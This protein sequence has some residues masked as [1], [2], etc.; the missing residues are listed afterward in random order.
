MKVKDFAKKETGLLIKTD[1]GK[2]KLKAVKENIINIVYTKKSEFRTKDSYML[3]KGIGEN[4]DWDIKNRED[5]LEFYTSKIKIVINKD[6]CSFKYYDENKNMLVKEPD[7]GGKTLIPIDVNKVIFAES[8]ELKQD[9]SAD[10]IKIRQEKSKEVFDRQAYSF[11]L[12]FDWDSEEA[13]YG[14]GSHEEGIMNYRGHQQLL[15]Q[16]NLKAVLPFI[17]STKGYGVLLDSYSLMTFHDDMYGSYLWSEVNEELNY[18]FIS[19]PEFDQIISGY[20]YL[21]GKAP[22]FPRWSLGYIQSK[23]RYKD[24]QE[25]IEVVAEHRKRGIPLDMIVLDWQSWPANL[26]G[27]KSLDSERFPDPKKMMEQIH[28]KNARLMVSIWPKMSNDGP[29]QREMKSKGFLLGDRSTYDAFDEKARELYWQQVHRGLFSKDIDAWWCDCTEPFDA[30]WNGEYKLEPEQRLTANTEETKKYIDPEYLNAYSLLHAKGIYRGQRE[31]TS[32]KRVVNLTRSS[33]AGQQRYGAITWSGDVTADWETFKKQIP[34]GLNFCA[35][36]VPYWTTDIG[37]FFV[38][39]KEQWFWSGNFEKGPKDDGYKELYVRW[40][41]FGAFTPFFRSH[42]TDFPR[43]I[44][45]FGEPGS[46]FYDTLL[47]FDKLRYRLIPYIYSLAAMVSFEDYTMM[48]ALAFDFRHDK[49]TYDIDDQ[50][51]FGP[52]LLVNPV[53]EAL[54]YRADSR[55]IKGKEKVRNV[56]LPQGNDWYDFWTGERYE[57]GQR[58]KAQATLDRIPLFVQAGSI[59][60]LGPE[61]QYTGQKPESPLELRIYPGKDGEFNLY[62]DEGDNYNYEKGNYEF[63]KI[64]WND[65]S[66]KLT[67]SKRE[68]SYPGMPEERQFKIVLCSEGKGTGLKMEKKVIKEKIIYDGQ[69]KSIKLS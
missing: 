7:R 53:T 46:I 27:Q 55:E 6:N 22:L 45:R 42:G 58:I 54:Y 14:L 60:P 20:R 39:D 29:D 47:K 36:G 30:D 24:Q 33:Y 52:A 57:G 62:F 16:H 32:D 23:E 63:I 13:I 67:C 48:R 26:W 43:E 64:R 4:I 19:G 3:V 40:F 56:Y 59:I 25:L 21:T 61:I 11:K 50:Y 68:G 66:R 37:G 69:Q 15:Y 38:K 9:D 8:S 1:Q 28:Q 35:A 17:I 5:E 41:Q 31:T 65:Q 34:A 44:W 49:K 12:E 51:L 2:L 18:Y 10:G